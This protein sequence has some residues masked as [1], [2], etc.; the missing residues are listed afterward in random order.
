MDNDGPL[1]MLDL[2]QMRIR[3]SV[4]LNKAILLRNRDQGVACERD[5]QD[6]CARG[7]GIVEE[8][9][10]SRGEVCK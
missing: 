6:I 2:E 8:K 7:V 10:D 9:E 5:H 3:Q 1:Y 4:G